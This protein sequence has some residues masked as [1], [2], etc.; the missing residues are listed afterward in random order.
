MGNSTICWKIQKQKADTLSTTE[1]EYMAASEA[2]QEAI[3]LQDLLSELGQ[4]KKMTTILHQDN[5]EA[6]FLEKNTCTKH[7]LS[8][9]TFDT[10]SSEKR[11]RRSGSSLL[12]SNGKG[13]SQHLYQASKENERLQDTSKV[14]CGSLRFYQRNPGK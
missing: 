8:T 11:S 12:I 2:I 5:H 4:M 7:E 10:T 14:L 3:C 6:I 13:D 1:A 9:S